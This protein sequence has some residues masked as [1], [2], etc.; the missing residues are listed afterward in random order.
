MGT[1]DALAGKARLVVAQMGAPT[2]VMN[3]SLWGFLEGA[4]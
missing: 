4:G 3:A 1:H 2:A